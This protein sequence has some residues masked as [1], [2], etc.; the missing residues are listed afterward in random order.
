MQFSNS[1]KRRPWWADL[2]EEVLE[3]AFAAMDATFARFRGMNMNDRAH[4]AR[5]SFERV[6]K[7]TGYGDD[8]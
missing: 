2:P 8:D 5:V 4:R 7:E 1:L 3:P 6:L